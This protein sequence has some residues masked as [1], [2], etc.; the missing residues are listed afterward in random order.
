M[1]RFEVR[2]VALAAAALYFLL[3]YYFLGP[4]FVLVPRFKWIQEAFGNLAEARISAHSTHALALLVAA[5][6]SAFLISIACR[7]RAIVVAA[8]AGGLT[9]VAA[10]V[11][12]FLSDLVRPLLD[13]TTIVQML[14]DGIKFV[15]ILI[16]ITWLST[17]LPPNY[18]MQRSSRVVAGRGR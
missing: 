16:F 14:I 18:A 17:K 3:A 8:A 5:I 6:P 1:L 11:P 4:V 7:P 15:L 10:F 2:Y 13:A 12:T 9:A